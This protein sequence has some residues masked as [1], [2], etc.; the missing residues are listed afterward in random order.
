MAQPAEPG[1][2]T[3][4]RNAAQD[5]SLGDLFAELS[6]ETTE[7]VRQEMDLAK[8]E[9]SHKAAEAGKDVS[10]LAAGGAVAYAGL[11]AVIA[12]V[13]IGLAQAGVTWWVSALL[14]G[15]VVAAIGA[16]LIY[17]GL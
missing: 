16:G 12:A 7:L 4:Q 6:R 2:V 1:Y 9:M 8:T 17:S 5:R 14:V 13:I 3:E 10:Y 11:L 15:L